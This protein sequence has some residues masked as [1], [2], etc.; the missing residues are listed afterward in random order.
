MTFSVS[1]LRLLQLKLERAPGSYYLIPRA[2]QFGVTTSESQSRTRFNDVL[3]STNC[4]CMHKY[5]RLFRQLRAVIPMSRESFLAPRNIKPV[6]I[7]TTLKVNLTPQEKQLCSLL[8]GCR[9]DLLSQGID[10]E[11]RI[12]GGWVRDKVVLTFS[13]RAVS[14]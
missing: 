5:S 10:V 9:A 14:Q 2:T 7:P 8:D 1:G 4:H 13:C 6:S 11:C 12:A 3:L